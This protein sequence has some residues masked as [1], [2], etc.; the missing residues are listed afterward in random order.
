MRERIAFIVCWLAVAS[1]GSTYIV[2][3][4]SARNQT[5]RGLF[6]GGVFVAVIACVCA[7]GY[8]MYIQHSSSDIR[9]GDQASPAKYKPAVKAAIVLQAIMLVLAALALDGGYTFHVCAVAIPAFWAM[10]WL[11][12]FRR[13]LPTQ[14]DLFAIRYG[15]MVI[16]AFVWTIAPFWWERS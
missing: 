14:V 4:W 2:S 7:V 1:A 9:A 15:Y 10:A 12:V 13:R 3:F 5:V 6:L 16:V 8:R 11:I